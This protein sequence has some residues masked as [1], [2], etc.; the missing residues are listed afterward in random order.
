MC[1]ARR[2]NACRAG[3]TACGLGFDVTTNP[4]AVPEHVVGPA[5]DDGQVP[6]PL[7]AP[8]VQRWL[9]HSRFGDMLIEV[10]GADVFVNGQRVQPHDA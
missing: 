9:W 3:C 5:A 8:G 10:V 4:P 6:L 2:A 1:T 7:A